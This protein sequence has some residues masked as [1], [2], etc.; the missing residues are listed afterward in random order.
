MFENPIGP[1]LQRPGEWPYGE[2][3]ILRRLGRKTTGSGIFS[4]APFENFS[5]NPPSPSGTERLILI[6]IYP[7]TPSPYRLPPMT[8]V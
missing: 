1:F 6:P 7:S 5:D 3:G 2:V 8:P 4:I